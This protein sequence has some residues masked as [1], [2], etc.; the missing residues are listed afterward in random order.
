MG[1]RGWEWRDSSMRFSL[2]QL[3]QGRVFV[4]GKGGGLGDGKER[5]WGDGPVSARIRTFLVHYVN[6]KLFLLVMLSVL[7]VSLEYIHNGC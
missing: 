6:I 5:V 1:L 4:Y 7:F 2:L 3:L